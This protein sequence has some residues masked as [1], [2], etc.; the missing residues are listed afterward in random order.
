MFTYS[1]TIGRNVGATPMSDDMWSMFK[2]HVFALL[3]SY[4]THNGDVVE[5]HEGVGV[6][7]GE[8]EQSCKVTLLAVHEIT[9]AQLADLRKGLTYYAEGHNQDAIAL[10]IGT[11]ELL[12]ARREEMVGYACH[13]NHTVDCGV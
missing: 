13:E 8:T 7:H 12:S 10:T 1:A 5:Q 6:W 3:S 2:G 11:S 9:D 4:V